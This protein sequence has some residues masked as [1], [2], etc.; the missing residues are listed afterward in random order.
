MC[1]KC[2]KATVCVYVCVCVFG[3]NLDFYDKEQGIKKTDF[4]GAEMTGWN[5]SHFTSQ[6][7]QSCGYREGH[8]GG[9]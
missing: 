1:L 7:K 4:K 9:S 5:S 6:E 8:V 3:F 2:R